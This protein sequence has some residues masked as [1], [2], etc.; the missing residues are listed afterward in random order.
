MRAAAVLSI[1]RDGETI[2]KVPVEGEAMLGRAE[3]C[4][5]R[6]DDRAISRQHA[7]FKAVGDGV[8]VEKKSVFAPLI[9]NGE[10]CTRAVLKE[11]DV[12]ALGPYLVKLSISRAREEPPS[13]RSTVEM[14]DDSAPSSGS[15]A[16]S[17]PVPTIPRSVPSLMSAPSSGA[18]A[19][20]SVAMPTIPL[21][22]TGGQSAAAA[23]AAFTSA[24]AEAT[25]ALGSMVPPTLEL[26]DGAGI[27]QPFEGLPP[28]GTPGLSAAEVA[29]L[30]LGPAGGLELAA[31]GGEG[32]EQLPPPIGTAA[33]E[34]GAGSNGLALPGA[35]MEGHTFA[36][37]EASVGTGSGG[38]VDPDG[39]T[40]PLPIADLRARLVLKTGKA[41]KQEYD[42][43]KG[44]ITI[45]RGKDCDIVL[46]DKKV[47][48]KNTVITLSGNR[49]LIRDMGSANGT[50]VNGKQVSEEQLFGEDVIRI[51]NEEFEFQ[52]L[53]ANYA[54]R[55][56]DFMAVTQG[57]VVQ[58]SPGGALAG[59]SVPDISI[60]PPIDGAENSQVGIHAESGTPA[61]LQI[62]PDLR[63]P[64]D[65]RPVL[66]AV[67]PTNMIPMGS[68]VLQGPA[69]VAANAGAIP[70]LGDPVANPL[71]IPGLTGLPGANAQPKGM[72]AKLNALPPRRRMMAFGM[73]IVILYL[74]LFDDD[75]A[76]KVQGRKPHPAAAASPIP[77]K[78]T[79][80]TFD[81][82]SPEKK[83][84]IEAQH[85]L[86]FDH[87]RNQEYEKALHETQNILDIL[88][89][90]YKD[91][92]EIQRYAKEGLRK[93]EAEQEELRRKQD[94]ELRKQQIE[95]LLNQIK[96]RMAAKDYATARELFTKVIELDPENQLIAQWKKEID[97]WEEQL[98]IK[99]Q[100]KDVQDQINQRGWDIFK[101]GMAL[102]KRGK[103]HAAI[104]TFA[105][106]QDVGATD[107]R[108]L[109][110]SR[111]AIATCKAII[112]AR[113]D[114]VLKDAHAA[115][116]AG[117]LKKALDLYEKATQI[118]PPH[119]D[120][121]AGLTRVKG[122]IHERAKS[123]YTEAVLAESY[124]DFDSARR[125]F[126]EIFDNTPKDDEY[127]GRA[128]R[129]L[130]KYQGLRGLAGDSSGG[131]QQQ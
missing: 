128:E 124:S 29:D 117:S 46:D 123:M 95:Q 79:T 56:K 30:D 72:L 61:E 78:A 93:Q 44:E 98:R 73:I 118:D 40:R 94:E 31:N 66:Y 104:A 103:Y 87:Y 110:S 131:S 15:A 6:L 119:P 35:P 100:E 14:L 2:R 130:E 7:L 97:D 85:Q 105:R 34:A 32:A 27:A 26:S 41:E 39:E 58:P 88:P 11:G 13:G 55:E 125:K 102:K 9:I 8:Q 109:A 111:T 24:A 43:R 108:V 42:L 17:R 23:L 126:Q 20:V 4:L 5:I 121:W 25:P 22:P 92:V 60:P 33:G 63:S 47:S 69:P 28:Q 99:Q 70:G 54:R 114:P 52:A 96:G 45:G 1:I 127:H 16:P 67:S 106:V 90:G 38:G 12:I 113:R 65:G 37:S 68:G 64:T 80:A 21:P 53:S 129:K 115:E 91:T 84:Y 19:P 81:T 122:V 3:G 59:D 77:A 82:L 62:P 112:T 86:A 76:P 51:G 75:E 120:G 50:Y 101:E 89:D 10:D 18:A 83:Q 74:G 36:L 49:F 71:G 57:S 107:R 48:R 116:D